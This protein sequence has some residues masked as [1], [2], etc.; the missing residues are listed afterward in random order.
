MFTKTDTKKS[1]LS[2]VWYAVKIYIISGYN[3]DLSLNN[4]SI[5]N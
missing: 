4:L 1:S 5:L 2:N 3:N